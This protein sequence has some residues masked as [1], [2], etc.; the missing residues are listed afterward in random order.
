LVDSLGDMHSYC[1]QRFGAKVEFEYFRPKP[2]SLLSALSMGTRALARLSSN[3]ES[4]VESLANR[5]QLHIR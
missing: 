1:E 4:L 3:A 5:F 2:P